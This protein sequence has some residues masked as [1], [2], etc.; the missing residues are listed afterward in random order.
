MDMMIDIE[1]L[2]TKP[3]ATV[4]SVGA[5]TFDRAGLRDSFYREFELKPQFE[6]CHPPMHVDASTLK[7][8][9]EQNIKPPIYVGEPYS[10]RNISEANRWIKS[11]IPE[12]RYVWANSPQFDLVLLEVLF[13][14]LRLDETPPWTH[15]QLRDMRTAKDFLRKV[16][17]AEIEA[18][19]WGNKHNA[20]YDAEW[21]ALYLIKAGLFD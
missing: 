5:V 8:W 4:L 2:G 21:Q 14:R 7:W 1:T 6:D 10:I 13:C 11:R 3:G 12:T 9:M 19:V 18:E 16:D 17:D 20:L 15:R